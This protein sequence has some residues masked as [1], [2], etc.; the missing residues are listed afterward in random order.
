M[1]TT[2]IETN[3]LAGDAL[4]WAVHYANH[5]ATFGNK[6]IN[7]DDKASAM[8]HM[9][10][11]TSHFEELATDWGLGMQFLANERICTFEQD[12]LWYGVHSDDILGSSQDSEGENTQGIIYQSD[13]IAGESMLVAGLR[14]YVFQVLGDKVEIPVY[15]ANENYLTQWEA[16]VK[17]EVHRS[18]NPKP[19]IALMKMLGR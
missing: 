16:D 18:S 8:A 13:S 11:P 10:N 14:S 4:N 12:G 2:T 15:L 5:L 9:E 17:E 6:P 7:D 3:I 1:T 19:G